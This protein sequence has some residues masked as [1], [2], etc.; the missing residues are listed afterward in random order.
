MEEYLNSA[1][2]D[3]VMADAEAQITDEE[4]NGEEAAVDDCDEATPSSDEEAEGETDYAALVAEDI[5][6]LKSIFPELRRMT[7]ITELKDPLRYAA[8]RDLGLTPKEAYLATEGASRRSDNRSH[9]VGALPKG[10]SAPA[11]SISRSELENARMLFGDLSDRQ[12]E[13]LYKKVIG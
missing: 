1:E 4:D 8:L 13:R 7:R 2:A 5:R 9:L 6:T 11:G 10:V 12:I 3:A